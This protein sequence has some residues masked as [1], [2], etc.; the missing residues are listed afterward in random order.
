MSGERDPERP[1]AAVQNAAV[2]HALTARESRDALALVGALEPL[3]A[4]PPG[5]DAELSLPGDSHGQGPPS[6]LSPRPHSHT[7]LSVPSMVL[8]AVFAAWTGR[9]VRSKRDRR[10]AV[11]SPTATDPHLPLAGDDASAPP[12]VVG[13]V[14]ACERFDLS[15]AYAASLA[16]CEVSAVRQMLGGRGGAGGSANDPPSDQ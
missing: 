11:L 12:A 7:P 1:I 3:R 9:R 14:V 5:P 10:T 2:E 8:S 15:P 16:D 6:E 4:R 13:A